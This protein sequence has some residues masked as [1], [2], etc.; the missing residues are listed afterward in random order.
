MQVTMNCLRNTRCVP[1]LAA[2]SQDESS[3]DDSEV[4]DTSFAPTSPRYTASNISQVANAAYDPFFGFPNSNASPTTI[5]EAPPD[6]F[7]VTAITR[8]L[9]SITN[10]REAINECVDDNVAFQ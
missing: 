6:E 10:Q 2:V 9:M 1:V 5:L 3:A 7:D 8:Q 4:D